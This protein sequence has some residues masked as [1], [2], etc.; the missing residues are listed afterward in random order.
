VKEDQR[1]ELKVGAWVGRPAEATCTRP[2]FLAASPPR[3]S[4][5][6]SGTRLFFATAKEREDS[7]VF[8]AVLEGIRSDGMV[9]DRRPALAPAP[10]QCPAARLYSHDLG[11]QLSADVRNTPDIHYCSE[12]LANLSFH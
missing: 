5:A 4:I 2:S 11:V 9:P 1:E 8:T 6:A 12:W 7:V 3:A 10:L